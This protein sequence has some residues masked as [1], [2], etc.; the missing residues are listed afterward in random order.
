M[1]LNS[2]HVNRNEETA[3]K[4]SLMCEPLKKFLTGNAKYANFMHACTLRWG[5]CSKAFREMPETILGANKASHMDNTD[6]KS[7]ERV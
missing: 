2:A 5:A 1:V 3:T 4:P 6:R 7:T